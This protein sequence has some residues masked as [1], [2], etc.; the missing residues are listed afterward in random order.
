MRWLANRAKQT[1]QTIGVGTYT[2]DPASAPAG[3][4]EL[5]VAVKKAS[6]IAVGPWPVEYEVLTPTQWEAGWG[7]LTEGPPATMQRVAVLESS[8][9]GDVAVTASVLNRMIRT[10][11]ET[12]FGSLVSTVEWRVLLA[13]AADTKAVEHGRTVPALSVLRV[14]SFYDG[15]LFYTLAKERAKDLRGIGSQSAPIHQ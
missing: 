5:V 10:N 4:K 6:G 13:L 15:T 14:K 9:V 11:R 7:L 1:T 8:E 12:L 2:I 3:F